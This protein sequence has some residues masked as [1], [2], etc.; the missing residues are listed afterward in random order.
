MTSENTIASTG[1]LI[2]MVDKLA[3][4]LIHFSNLNRYSWSQL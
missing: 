1:L 3:I 4:I 2:L